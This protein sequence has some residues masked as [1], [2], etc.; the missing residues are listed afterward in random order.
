MSDHD[1]DKRFQRH[2]VIPSSAPMPTPKD[3]LDVVAYIRCNLRRNGAMSVEGH[4]GDRRFALALIDNARDAIERQIPSNE[5]MVIPGRE[6]SVPEFGDFGQ[7]AR[8]IHPLATQ[9][10][11]A[12]AARLKASKLSAEYPLLIRTEEGTMQRWVLAGCPLVVEG[13]P[14][15]KEPAISDKLL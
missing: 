14:V 2:R 7:K 3:D 4:I 15:E 1:I 5:N 9:Y 11:T 12:H 8:P 13:K 6:V 10:L